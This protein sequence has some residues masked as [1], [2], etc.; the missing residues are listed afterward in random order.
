MMHGNFWS[1]DIHLM[2]PVYLILKKNQRNEK[3]TLCSLRFIISVVDFVS[4]YF[5]ASCG[6]EVE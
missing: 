1:M 4:N 2:I 5:F 6:G 3:K